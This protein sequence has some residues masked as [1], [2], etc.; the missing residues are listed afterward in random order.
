MNR[1][2]QSQ[3]AGTVANLSGLYGED[4]FEWARRNAE[5]LR[6]GRFGEADIRHIAEELEDMGK[7]ELHALDNRTQV[8]LTHLLKWQFQ[9]GKRSPSWRRTIATQRLKMQRLFRQS[10]SVG[11]KLDALIP[12]KYGDEVSFAVI[13]T[14]LSPGSFPADCPYTVEQIL[15]PEFLP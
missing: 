4:F 7:S 15:D 2:V 3:R 6:A 14:G 11:T 1:N 13:E 12:E 9:P 5:L 10:P 8:L